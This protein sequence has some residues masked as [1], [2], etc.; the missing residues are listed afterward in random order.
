M[1]NRLITIASL[2][3]LSWVCTAQD[4]TTMR[5]SKIRAASGSTSPSDI[6]GLVLWLK[7]ESLSGSDGTQISSWAD[8]SGNS[9]TV[10]QTVAGDRP[11]MTNNVIGTFEAAY[12]DTSDRL[13][14]TSAGALD[15]TR[16]KS[17]HTVFI[18][19]QTVATPVAGNYFYWN[20]TDTAANNRATLA[21]NTTTTYRST[22]R[23]LDADA[24]FN[25]DSGDA[26][27][28]ASPKLLCCIWDWAN[29]D[30]KTWVNGTANIN[31]T[32]FG[33]DGSTSDT[34]SAAYQLG[35]R[36]SY[37]DG[38]TCEWIVYNRALNDTER[39][40]VESYINTKY[41]LW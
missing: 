5:R 23:R 6:S 26:T 17:G 20:S 11:V 36:S 38:W 10:E 24:S 13:A 4:G 33:T 15:A 12:F 37:F 16:N 39:Q 8:S 27:V 28:L 25:S 34:A 29:S 19:M 7:P 18:V 41:A 9:Y 31:D 35:G 32:T 14:V 30:F 22:A 21:F 40:A 3:I 2:V 1:V